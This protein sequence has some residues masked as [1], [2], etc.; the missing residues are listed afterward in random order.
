MDIND[1]N[2]PVRLPLPEDLHREVEIIEPEGID[3][4][5]EDSIKRTQKVQN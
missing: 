3:E 2:Q 1:K 5:W 4:N